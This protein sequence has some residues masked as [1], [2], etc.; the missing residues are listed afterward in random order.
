MENVYFWFRRDL[1]LKD[2]VG[3]MN[4]TNS[5]KKVQCVFIFDTNILDQ[6]TEDDARVTF[7]HDQLSSIDKALKEIGSVN[8]SSIV[9]AFLSSDQSLIEMAG[10]KNMYNQG[11]N[12]KK[13]LKSARPR[14]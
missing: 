14:S 9:P 12:S 6:L 3:L 11:W 5:G 1:R 8:V 13:G 4:A 2:N 7:I 10:I